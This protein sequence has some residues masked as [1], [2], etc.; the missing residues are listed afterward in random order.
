M[1]SCIKDR[2]RHKTRNINIYTQ[3]L[4]APFKCKPLTRTRQQPAML[5]RRTNEVESVD[6]NQQNGQYSNERDDIVQNNGIAVNRQQLSSGKS[7]DYF[8]NFLRNNFNNF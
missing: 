5:R 6:F 3:N 2:T 1:Y 8:Y 7:L 4:P